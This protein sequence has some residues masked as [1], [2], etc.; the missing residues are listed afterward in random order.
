MDAEDGSRRA[1]RGARPATRRERDRVREPLGRPAGPRR[2]GPPGPRDTARSPT[3]SGSGTLPAGVAVGE[4]SV[5]VTNAGDGT[6][7]RIDVETNEVSQTTPRRRRP[8]PGSRWATAS[9][10]SPTR[11]AARSCGSIRARETPRRCRSPGLP[12]GVAFTPEGVWVSVAPDSVARVDPAGSE[13]RLHPAG[14]QRADGG[15]CRRSARSGSRTIS[16][17]PS[18]GSS[19]PRAS[20]EATIPV[21]Q[22][23]NALGAAAGSCGSRTSSTTP[24]SRSTQ[25]PTTSSSPFRSA[26]R[27][28]RSPADERWTVARRRGIGDRASRRNPDGLLRAAERRRRSTRRVAYDTERW[29][30][31]TITN[32]GLWLPEGRWPGRSD[33]RPGPG[34]GA[35]RRLRRRS[36]LPVPAPRRDPLLDGRTGPTRGLP[37]RRS[38][39]A[40]S[41]TSAGV[42]LSAIEGADACTPEDALRLRPLGRIEVDDE[43]VTF[44]LATPDPELPLQARPAVRL[45]GPGRHPGRGLRASSRSRRPGRT[46]SREAGPK[47]IELERNPGFRE[48]SAAAQPDGFV[49]AISWRFD[50]EPREAFD[51]L[52]GGDVDV[53]VDRAE[54]GGPGRPAARPTPTRSSLAGAV[55]AVRRLRRP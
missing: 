31:L 43:A 34:V 24:S 28:R 8:R 51:Q 22:G 30:I 21:G 47:R 19:L 50:E 44:H 11:S 32:D 9:C 40:S 38:S 42:S 5:W 16:T 29:R 1:R 27:P 41:C 55:H 54:P 49:D 15:R 23:P 37:A 35:P 13:R 7:S 6:V 46:W 45:P 26:A 14:G 20:I 4:G 12:S 39:G 25:R 52:E 2:R 17:A 3:Q 33:A 10:G 36:D 53:M 18:P 48:W